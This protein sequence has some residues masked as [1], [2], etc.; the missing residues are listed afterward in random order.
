MDSLLTESLVT[1]D[2]EIRNQK[3]T[4]AINFAMADTPLVP[5]FYPIFD[6]AAKKDLVVTPRAQRRFNALMISEKK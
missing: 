4:R 6:F 2:D 5:V 3:L 1:M